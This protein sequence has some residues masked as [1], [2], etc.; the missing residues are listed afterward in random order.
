MKQ[1]LIL[2][3]DSDNVILSDSETELPE[4]MVAAGDNTNVNGS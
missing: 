3:H 2:E 4:D 1:D